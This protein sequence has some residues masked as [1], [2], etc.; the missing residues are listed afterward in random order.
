MQA[1]STKGIWADFIGMR[2]G[3]L[4]AKCNGLIHVSREVIKGLPQLTP[5]YVHGAGSK[6]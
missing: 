3:R 6:V 2:R 5:K 4:H 1:S